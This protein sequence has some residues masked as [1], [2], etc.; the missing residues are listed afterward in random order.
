MSIDFNQEVANGYMPISI[1]SL[2]VSL[3]SFMG[4][5]FNG[6][7]Y[8]NPMRNTHLV[9]E[10]RLS[11]QQL[12]NYVDQDDVSGR[13]LELI[14]DYVFKK[15]FDL[16]D[17]KDI[18]LVEAIKND[19][20]RLRIKFHSKQL[21]K[22]AFGFGRASFFLNIQGDDRL[23]TELI[24]DKN[25]K[26]QSLQVLPASECMPGGYVRYPSGHE[27][28]GEPIQWWCH[29]PSENQIENKLVHESRLIHYIP[30]PPLELKKKI[31]YQFGGPSLI[32][33]CHEAIRGFQVAVETAT[34]LF[35]KF[36]QENMEM[37]IEEL[38]ADGIERMKKFTAFVAQAQ[39]AFKIGIHAKD[40]K[41][42]MSAV[43]TSGFA[44][45]FQQVVVP[46]LELVTP[47]SWS[48]LTGGKGNSLG[49][50]ATEEDRTSTYDN[51]MAIQDPILTEPLQKLVVLSG[52]TQGEEMESIKVKLRWNPLFEPTALERAEIRDKEA[53]TRIKYL[54]SGVMS[55]EETRTSL[56]EEAKE[57]PFF[58]L[59]QAAF[60]QA[61]K[62]RQAHELEDFEQEQETKK[63][64]EETAGGK[65]DN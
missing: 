50:N 4:N 6:T 34:G 58:H 28:A 30:Y 10:P 52:I 7:G 22:A 21:V 65:D 33:K 23:D 26:I 63:L 15:G 27:K 41:R 39:G 29:L 46:R 62:E 64:A 49:S 1:A 8:S 44:E 47:F 14:A 42:S 32:Q 5:A 36:V 25:T 11:L 59:D 57:D 45:L 53:D 13:L 54:S 12:S 17:E 38:D 43:P 16:T 55:V 3:D 2:G 18:D 40:T 31:E 24:F 35:P 20:E 60:E 56:A 48:V 19:F 51:I 9:S 61:E 37:P